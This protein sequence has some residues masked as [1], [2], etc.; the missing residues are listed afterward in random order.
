MWFTTPW[1]PAARW[2][3]LHAMPALVSQQTPPARASRLQGAGMESLSQEADAGQLGV[4]PDAEEW[5]LPDYAPGAPYGMLDYDQGA[6]S[7]TYQAPSPAVQQPATVVHAAESMPENFGAHHAW[8]VEPVLASEVPDLPEDDAAGTWDARDHHSSVQPHPRYFDQGPQ[9]PPVPPP[10]RLSAPHTT[11]TAAGSTAVVGEIVPTRPLWE[12]RSANS[13]P[14]QTKK[15]AVTLRKSP[16][17][18]RL[19]AEMVTVCVV[20]RG[21]DSSISSATQSSRGI[22][23]N[24]CTLFHCTLFH[25]AA[26]MLMPRRLQVS[27]T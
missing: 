18:R 26:R 25:C 15:S 21:A 13:T 9:E 22:V 12:S 19:I 8:I 4:W 20:Y 6:P 16:C 24:R 14:K 23:W 2:P 3:R 17:C 27:R 5:F 1:R 7:V 10:E 11:R